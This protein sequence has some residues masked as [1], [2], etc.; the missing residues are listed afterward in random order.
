[1]EHGRIV[2]RVN[3]VF[4]DHITMLD[5]V[6]R[7]DGKPVASR[8]PVFSHTLSAV[9]TDDGRDLRVAG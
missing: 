6:M 3:V 4:G 2:R 5:T 9:R 1:M 8:E 7:H